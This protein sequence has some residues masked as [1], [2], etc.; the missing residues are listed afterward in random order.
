MSDVNK[1]VQNFKDLVYSKLLSR[2]PNFVEKF[3]FL[4]ELLIIEY[5]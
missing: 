5:W 3:D 2:S 4:V 1:F